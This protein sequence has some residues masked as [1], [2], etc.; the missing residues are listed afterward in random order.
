[1]LSWT[2]KSSKVFNSTMDKYSIKCY[3]NYNDNVKALTKQDSETGDEGGVEHCWLE[4]LYPALHIHVAPGVDPGWLGSL[5]V[6]LLGLGPALIQS[7]SVT[8]QDRSS[9]LVNSVLVR[10][11]CSFSVSAWSSLDLVSKY[12]IFGNFLG[13]RR[14]IDRSSGS[15]STSRLFIG[16]SAGLSRG[17][18]PPR[19]ERLVLNAT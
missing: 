14:I 7:S 18:F 15:A 17:F 10:G 13:D 5:S 6:V 1:M 8:L 3:I 2:I 11:T 19:T 4:P 9:R 16:G 12:S